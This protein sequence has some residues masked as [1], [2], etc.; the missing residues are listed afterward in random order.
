M[1]LYVISG[2]AGMTG[3]ELAHRL[4]ER[5]DIV[6]GFDNFFA[7]SIETVADILAESN[8]LFYEYDLNSS[9]QMRKLSEKILDL[10]KGAIHRT[11]FINCAAVVHTKHFYEVEHTFQTN[12][13]SM[14]AFLEICGFFEIEPWEFFFPAIKNPP[15]IHELI[16]NF[17]KFP[18]QDQ[19]FW[20][21]ALNR[22]LAYY[23]GSRHILE[24]TAKP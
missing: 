22:I 9:E 12:V 4:L 7:S 13:L 3:S 16:H 24:P 2:V 6:V 14:K 8:F 23:E 18:D 20:L 10:K 5:G 19:Q 21:L 17:Q 1:N 11:V 15:M